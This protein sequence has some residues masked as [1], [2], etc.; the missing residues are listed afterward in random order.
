M[1]DETKML[2]QAIQNQFPNCCVLKLE[3][4]TASNYCFSSDKI[5]I[6]TDIPFDDLRNYLR[7][8]TDRIYIYRKGGLAAISGKISSG[9]ILGRETEVEFIEIDSING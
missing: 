1:R 8:I 4:R 6:K 9:T 5:K 3:Y 7:K 2:K